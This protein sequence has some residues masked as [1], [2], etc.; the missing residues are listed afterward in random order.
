MRR[1]SVVASEVTPLDAGARLLGVGSPVAA[2]RSA[3]SR[4]GDGVGGSLRAA[5]ERGVARARSALDDIVAAAAT[6]DVRALRTAVEA[7]A[8]ASKDL[9]IAADDAQEH[10]LLAKAIAD[11][12]EFERQRLE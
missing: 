12:K 2:V 7:V 9:A 8:A 1:K 10:V 3:R 5:V 4:M 6:A 11:T